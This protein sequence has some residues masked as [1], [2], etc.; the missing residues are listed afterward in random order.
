ML[1]G[2]AYAC[3]DACVAGEDWS[4]WCYSMFWCCC[5]DACVTGE[6]GHYDVM[7]WCCC[8][9]AC[10]TGEIGH[11]DV[12]FWCCCADACVTGEDWS[13][14]C[15]SMFWCC[16]AYACVAGEDWS[17]WCYSMFLCCCADAC[18][19]GE[20]WSLWCYSM[21]WCC[22]ADA[23]VAGEDWSLW[24]YSMFWCCCADAC[25]TGEDWSV[26]CY[27]LMLLCRCLCHR[28]G[29]VIMMLQYVLMLLCRCLCRWWGLVIMMLQYV[30]MLL[31]RCLCHWWGLVIMMLCF[32]VVVQ[33]LVSLVR[34]GHYD[35]MFWCCCADACVTGEDW[36]VWCY[37]LMLLC[38]CLCRWWWLVIMMLCFDV[39]VQ[40]LVSLVRIGQYDVMFWCCCADACVA[41]DDWSLWCYVLMLL[42]RCLCRWWGLV[43][44]MLCFDVVVQ[45]LVSLV[46]TG[47][48]DV[49]FWC[50]CAD[51]CVTGDDWSVWCYVLMLLCRC[52]CRWW[53]LVIMMLCFDVVV[54]MLVSL[55]RI[56]HYDVMFWCCCAYACVAGEDWSVWCYVLMLL[57]RCLC[58]WWGL[59]SVMLLYLMATFVNVYC[60]TFIRWETAKWL[61]IVTSTLDKLTLSLP[62]SKGAVPNLPKEKCMSEVVRIGSIIISHL[63]KRWKAKFFTLCDVI[64][65]VKL[66]GKFE[67]DHSAVPSEQ[68][69]SSFWNAPFVK[70]HWILSCQGL[71]SSQSLAASPDVDTWTTG[72]GIQET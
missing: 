40:M 13:V 22:C 32:D 36:S 59:V 10:V 20:D 25:V 18:V 38:R 72:C 66:Q 57:C 34:I 5:A 6:I 65:L 52:L 33:M 17:L 9:Y 21:F 69:R 37:F 68:N 50:C 2:C 56:S 16:C 71:E 8:A 64:S 15:Y 23:C 19:A 26:W 44:M 55:V 58:H 53:W 54:Q 4:L 63:S 42:C 27:V 3:A 11:Y 51:A 29:L 7:F 31:C 41:G 24:C 70:I 35:V 39:V 45:M 14:W 60:G 49:M 28:W 46:R 30:L 61:G 43:I 48:Y 12:M 62:S 1:C 47:H 67:V